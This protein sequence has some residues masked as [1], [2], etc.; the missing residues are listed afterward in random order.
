MYQNLSIANLLASS[1]LQ[2]ALT[3]FWLPAYF[4]LL[5][6]R[7]QKHAQTTNTMANYHHH[8]HCLSTVH[9]L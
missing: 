3:L 1:K 9:S 5:T 4:L 7:I 8:P 6:H 2:V